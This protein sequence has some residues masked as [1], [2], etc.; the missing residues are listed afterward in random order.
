MKQIFIF[1]IIFLSVS[2]SAQRDT[3]DANTIRIYSEIDTATI[4]EGTEV[5]LKWF[6]E[7]LGYITEIDTFAEAKDDV[8]NTMIEMY[9]A[10]SISYQQN[11]ESMYS[12]YV[13]YN[14]LYQNTVRRLSM[15]H[16]M[17]GGPGGGGGGSTSTEPLVYVALITQSGTDAPVATVLKNTLGGTVV[18]TY[19]SGDYLG[20]LVGAF[21]ENKTVIFIGTNDAGAGYGQL[22]Y[23]DDIIGITNT[24][25][26]A[27]LVPIQILVYP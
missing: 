27:Y 9:Q 15:Y 7:Q 13:T 10:D 6:S 21:T 18:W 20:T 16:E 1:A 4:T 5:T 17:R 24:S 11:L 12:T 25:G 26:Y 23:S 22:W 2:L 19:D 3:L 14:T 8:L